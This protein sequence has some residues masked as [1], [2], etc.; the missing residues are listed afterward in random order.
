MVNKRI[1]VALGNPA[2]I[3]PPLHLEESIISPSGTP[4]IL[5]NPEILASL[6]AIPNGEHGMVDILRPI[7]AGIAGVDPSLVLLEAIDDLEGH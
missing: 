2:H 7:L 1:R 3:F 6:S 5:D 4:R